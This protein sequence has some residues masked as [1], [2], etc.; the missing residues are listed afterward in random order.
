[1]GKPMTDI[2][3]Q[4]FGRL[5]A[6]YPTGDKDGNNYIWHCECDCGNTTEVPSARL[7]N[8]GTMSCGC[9]RFEDIANQTFGLLKALYRVGSNKRGN[10]MWYCRCKCGGYKVAPLPSL[11]SGDTSSCGCL[12]TKKRG[13]GGIRI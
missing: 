5:V 9:I 4:R 12:R 8:E 3:E 7:R 6:K 10:T 13:A 11:K 2:A 1:M